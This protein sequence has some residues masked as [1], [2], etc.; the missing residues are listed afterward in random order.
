MSLQD[1]NDLST[2]E[3]VRLEAQ[4]A[5][6]E[7]ARIKSEFLANMSH[8]I[9]TPMNGVMGML[10]LLA[11]T[12]LDSEQQ[13]YVTVA[14]SAADSLLNVIDDILDF[15]KIESGKLELE[16]IDFDLRELIEDTASLLARRA[17]DKGLELV[18]F[19]PETIPQRVTGDPVRLRQ[20]LTNLL[21]N[22][23]KFTEQ[24]EVVLQ[25]RVESHQD[26]HST[27]FFEI[28]DTGIGISQTQQ[29]HVFEAFRQAEGS[30]TR[31]YGGT[32]LGL[33]IVRELVSKMDGAI[34]IQSELGEGATFWFTAKF[35]DSVLVEESSGTE[36]SGLRVLIVD[37]NATNRDILSRYLAQWGV[38]YEEAADGNEAWQ[39]VHRDG[40]AIDLIL[41]DTHMPGL[42]GLTL[43]ERIE[44]SEQLRHIPRIL[45]SSMGPEMR[46]RAYE[47]GCSAY[48]SKPVRQTSLLDAVATLTKSE[49]H[50]KMD[51][52]SVQSKRLKQL[53]GRVLL[54][55]DND[56]NRRVAVGHLRRMGITPDIAINGQEALDRLETEPYDLVLMDCQM[57]VMD[58]ME[59]TRLLRQR[60][61]SEDADKHTPI[62]ALTA[63]AMEG[64]RE[65]CIAVGMDDY[66]SKP[67]AHEELHDLLMRWLPE[68]LG[69]D[70]SKAVSESTVSSSDKRAGQP[71]LDD[72][73]INTVKELMEDEFA[74]LIDAYL[75]QTVDQI[76]EL[77]RAVEL[78]DPKSVMSI[79]HSIKSGS[80]NVG[81]LQLSV[82][83]HEFE[84]MG[85]NGRVASAT[86]LWKLEEAFGQVKTVLEK[87]KDQK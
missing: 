13:E 82:I 14:R 3:Q 1:T 70:G 7:A 56:V 30:V 18:A 41:L 76:A 67:F 51:R 2:I 72:E 43:S 34:G 63:H 17:Q 32:G 87:I 31:R 46:D 20:I 62:V 23:V 73:V 54:V 65:R 53:T 45:I 15:S 27:I 71:I 4:K 24:G 39:R 35:Q 75:A 47:V 74:N 77:H 9:R 48:L 42:D 29:R 58:G 40:P 5:L 44:T 83:A 86:M 26:G 81:A 28:K 79:G 22:A 59:S 11:D 19:V 12:P 64:D 61:S 57:P 84:Q 68:Q 78:E 8:E 10:E 36:F 16:A 85:K 50:A 49:H 25:T 80:A 55:E 21:G 60:E 66:L 37:D 6:E 52:P 69:S 33:A 38:A